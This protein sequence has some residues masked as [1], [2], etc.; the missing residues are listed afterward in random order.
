MY[1][2]DNIKPATDVPKLFSHLP[3]SSDPACVAPL[4]PTSSHILVSRLITRMTC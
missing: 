4:M 1:M 3:I 2:Y